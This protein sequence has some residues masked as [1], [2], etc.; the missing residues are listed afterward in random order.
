[1]YGFSGVVDYDEA[2]RGYQNFSG[3]FTFDSDTQDPIADGSSGAYA[4]IG[5]PWGMSLVFDS[6]DT[7]VISDSFTVLVSHALAGT[8]Q[9]GLLALDAEQGIS[10]TLYDFTASVLGGDA[11][12]LRDGG[13]TMADFGWSDMRWDSGAG[14]LMGRLESLSCVAGCSA[15]PPAAVPEPGGLALVATGLGA[16]LWR[17]RRRPTDTGRAHPPGLQ[18]A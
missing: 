16:L 11:L 8:D 17:M 4:H 6:G 3:S 13:Y 7:L 15:L 9:W 1:M 10:L 18:T 12:P 14:A 2:G 5:P